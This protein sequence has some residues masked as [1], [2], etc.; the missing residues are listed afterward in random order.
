MLN[1]P[2]SADFLS[3]EQPLWSCSS[4]QTNTNGKGIVALFS[5]LPILLASQ[6]LGGRF[7][8]SSVHLWVLN[9]RLK[10]T[11]NQDPPTSPIW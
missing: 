10:R 11:F 9:R 1:K 3:A 5:A 7:D 8:I 6:L 4:I 2:H